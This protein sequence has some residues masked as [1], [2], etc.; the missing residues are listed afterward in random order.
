MLIKKVRKPSV[1]MATR[2]EVWTVMFII[3]IA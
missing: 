2:V 3:D 1:K